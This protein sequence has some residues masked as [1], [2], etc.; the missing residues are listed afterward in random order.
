MNETNETNETNT[1]AAFARF[2]R[3][4]WDKT[5]P[6]YSE[7]FVPTTSQ[8][9]P[10]LL[11]HL[12]LSPPP[13]A[14]MT[15]LDVA[16]GPGFISAALKDSNVTVVGADLSTEMLRV[17]RE[18]NPGARFEQADA[19]ALPFPDESFD[20]VSCNFGLLHF[21]DPPAA[22]REAA[23]VLRRG[24]RYAYVVWDLP[25]RNKALSIIMTAVKPYVART[26]MPEGPPFFHYSDRVVG[27]QALERVG[28]TDVA[29]E[30]I[31]MTWPMRSAATVLTYFRDGGARIGEVLRQ[32]TPDAAREVE[33]SVAA[34]LAEY[35]S[36]GAPGGYVVPTAAVVFSGRK[37]V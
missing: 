29:I 10:C 7:G 15:L 11:R 12:R 2:E 5:G 24:G 13:D 18:L 25:E 35:D 17:A 19:E 1:F 31:P 4:F 14:P 28:L 3:E 34:A 23:R 16:C 20:A 21:G 9:V 27:Q 32:L 26:A 30:E 33:A 37:P 8:T 22:I 6:V 36:H